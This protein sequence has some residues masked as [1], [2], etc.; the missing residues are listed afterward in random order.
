MAKMVDKTK[1]KEFAEGLLDIFST[2][3][4]LSTGL[5]SKSNTNHTHDGRYYTET[6]VDGLLDTKADSSHTQASSTINALTGFSK[7][8]SFSALATTD[9]LNVAL[10]K[11][12][13]AADLAN[14]AYTH[15]QSAHAPSNAQK[16]SDITKS[17][18]EAK[19]TGTIT[20]HNHDSKY[21]TETEV[22]TLIDEVNT[23]ISTVSGKL[24][25]TFYKDENGDLYFV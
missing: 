23:S 25:V 13:K 6:E 4:E 19:L 14:T 3:K 24:P 5:A 10:G 15:S 21:Y 1:L 17:E 20:T 12:A 7:A 9:T 18:I 16:N 2:K 22:D 8:S 11:L